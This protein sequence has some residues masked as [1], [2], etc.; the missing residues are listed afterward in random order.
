MLLSSVA[1]SCLKKLMV[2]LY[3]NLCCWSCSLRLSILRYKEWAHWLNWV[4][5]LGSMPCPR[6]HLPLKFL[7]VSMKI[8]TF[9]CPAIHWSKVCLYSTY[10]WLWSNPNHMLV[11]RVLPYPDLLRGEDKAIWLIL[12]F[13]HMW[14]GL[15]P[16]TKFARQWAQKLIPRLHTWFMGEKEI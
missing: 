14:R 5:F 7:N 16:Q 10:Q 2:C 6:D 11:L 12:S 3:V 15:L 4:S 9:Q 8:L 13:E 1:F